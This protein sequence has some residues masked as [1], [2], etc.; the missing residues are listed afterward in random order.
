MEV[1]Q[2]PQLEEKKLRHFSTAER[3]TRLHTRICTSGVKS[4]S[5]FCRVAVQNLETDF[6]LYG[7][8]FQSLFSSEI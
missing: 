8:K 5:P 2:L 6:C 7:L 1:A 4:K 3:Y